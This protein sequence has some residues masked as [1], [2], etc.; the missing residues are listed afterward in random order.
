MSPK[1][2]MTCLKVLRKRHLYYLSQLI[3]PSGTHLI[4]WTTYQIAYIAY[5]AD[6]RGHSL[7]HKWYLDI[8]ATTTIPNSHDRLYDHYVCS[9]SSPPAIDLVPSCDAHVSFPSANKYTA[10]TPRCTFKISLLKSLILPTN[11]ERIC[12]NTTEVVSFYSWADLCDTVTSYYRRLITSPDFSSSPF[13]VSVDDGDLSQSFPLHDRTRLPSP[14][15]LPSGSHYRFYTDGSLINLSSSEVSMGWSWVQI[16]HDAGYLNS[17]AT[18]AH[19][20]ICN[21]PFSTR[22]ETAAIY[23]ALSVFLADSTIS[24]YTDSQTA[25]DGLHL[26]ASSVYTNSRLFYKITNFELCASIKHFIHAKRL[27]I[28]P[29]KVK[30][31]D[32]NYWNEFANSL[33]NS[34]YHSDNALLLPVADYISTHNV[35]LIYD[36]VVCESN[37]RRLFKLY[38]Q[39]T[40]MKDLLSLKR[41]QFTFCLCN[42]DDYVIDWELT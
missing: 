36:D 15:I 3:T 34:A 12:Q 5:L 8:Q 9:P 39:A 38:Y 11:C 25:I 16:I 29:V 4:S 10:V 33:A 32:G 35:H 13:S 22:A 2:F 1:I 17:V 18:Y 42:R 26:Y 23:A 20:T 41:F 31:H 40:F 19:G 30:G 14:V 24:I 37:P 7:P 6:K 27:M 21:W 28:Y